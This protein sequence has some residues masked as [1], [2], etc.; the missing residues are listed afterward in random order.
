MSDWLLLCLKLAQSCCQEEQGP[1]EACKLKWQHPHSLLLLF[2]GK[3]RWLS[4]TC[5]ANVLL[6]LYNAA[7]DLDEC[8]G[9]N[10]V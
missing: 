7:I 9:I 3:S 8:L 4:I 5:N 2:G 1:A 10:M 6:R